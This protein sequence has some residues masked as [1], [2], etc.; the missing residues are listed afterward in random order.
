MIK[1]YVFNLQKEIPGSSQALTSRRHSCG[2]AMFAC[3]I[4]SGS[5][6]DSEATAS[7]SL[8]I[9]RKIFFTKAVRY[10]VGRN[11]HFRGLGG[12]CW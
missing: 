11:G 5:L 9:H 8:Q 1:D 7:I 2:K 10:L 4:A 3:P 6:S 12:P